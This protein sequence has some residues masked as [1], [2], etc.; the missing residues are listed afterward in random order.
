MD[1]PLARGDAGAKALKPRA[2]RGFSAFSA[3]DEGKRMTGAVT[4]CVPRDPRWD[5]WRIAAG[6]GRGLGMTTSPRAPLSGGFLLACAIIVGVCVGIPLGQP[7]MGFVGG[8]VVGLALL[9]AVWLRET[10]RARRG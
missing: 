10:A 7:S 1:T 6:H 5:R 4:K 8:L 9:A 2:T 3:A